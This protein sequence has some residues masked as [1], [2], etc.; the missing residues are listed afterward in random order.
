MLMGLAPTFF[1]LSSALPALPSASFKSLDFLSFLVSGLYFANNLR[2]WLAID[3]NYIV[4]ILKKSAYKDTLIFVNCGLELM[5]SGRDLKSLKKNSLLSLNSYVFWPFY[6][7]SEISLGL[8]VSSNSKVSRILC[9]QRTL[10]SFSSSL[11]SSRCSNNF[12]ALWNFLW[13]YL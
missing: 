10:N 13:L 2:S 4:W 6:K 7:T 3:I 11:S 9:E 8:D 12:L 5:E 1:D